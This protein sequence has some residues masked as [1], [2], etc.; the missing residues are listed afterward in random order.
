MAVCDQNNTRREICNQN[1]DSL[2]QVRKKDPKLPHTAV[3][4]FCKQP[5]S[6]KLHYST[7]QSIT[8]YNALFESVYI[9]IL[10]KICWFAFSIPFQSKVTFCRTLTI[11][12]VYNSLWPLERDSNLPIVTTWIGPRRLL[13][14]HPKSFFSSTPIPSDTYSTNE[15]VSLCVHERET[16]RRGESNRKKVLCKIQYLARTPHS[17]SDRGI[18]PLFLLMIWVKKMASTDKMLKIY[19]FVSR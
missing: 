6:K 14:L 2:N 8:S 15:R 4:T 5:M 3:H 18:W 10:K 1:G 12:F 19:S 7:A 13:T 11:S 16:E 17:D 9:P